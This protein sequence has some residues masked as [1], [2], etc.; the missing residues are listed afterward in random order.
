MKVQ[1]GLQSVMELFMARKLHTARPLQ[2]QSIADIEKVFRSMQAGKSMA[3]FV[4]EIKPDAQVLV[5]L[6]AQPSF[7]LNPN[8]TYPVA[9][10]LGGCSMA[11]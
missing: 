1:Q 8:R 10:G 5:V 7:H 9:G 2:G 6:N 4:L 11:R 3:K